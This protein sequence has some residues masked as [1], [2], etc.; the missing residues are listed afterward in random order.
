M[1]YGGEGKRVCSNEYGVDQGARAGQRGRGEEQERGNRE[2][3]ITCKS[4]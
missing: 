3:H 1:L 4:T 2:Y